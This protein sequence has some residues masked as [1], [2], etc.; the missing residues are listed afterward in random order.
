MNDLVLGTWYLVLGNGG[1]RERGAREGGLRA[2]PYARRIA[3][4]G[5]STMAIAA[6]ESDLLYYMYTGD[7]A[8]AFA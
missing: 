2:G 5:L 7:G 1:R 6:A 3:A 4:K 8:T